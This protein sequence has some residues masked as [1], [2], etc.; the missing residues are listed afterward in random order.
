V[1]RHARLGIGGGQARHELRAIGIAGDNRAPSGLAGSQCIF[2]E[3][4][5]NAVFLAH[6]T[7]TC[8]AILIQYGPDIPA[9]L[10]MIR[11]GPMEERTCKWP[12]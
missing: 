6:P 10:H 7:V 3:Y 2:T 11:R 12:N 4:E 8:N 9:E 5:G 1:I